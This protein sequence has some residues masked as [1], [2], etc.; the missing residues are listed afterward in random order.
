MKGITNL[1]LQVSPGNQVTLL[2]FGTVHS[3]GSSIGS[4]CGPL[5]SMDAFQKVAAV[6]FAIEKVNSNANFTGISGLH[7]D[8]CNSESRAIYQSYRFLAGDVN[9][10][11]TFIVAEPKTLAMSLFTD[12]EPN[13]GLQ[14]MLRTQGIPFTRT[15]D[16]E[17]VLRARLNA[18]ISI[19]Q[20]LGWSRITVVRKEGSKWGKSALAMLSTEILPTVR[21]MCLGEDLELNLGQKDLKREFQLDLNTAFVLL[22]ETPEET[23]QILNILHDSKK[24]NHIVIASGWDES[25]NY[26][27]SADIFAVAQDSSTETVPGFREFITTTATSN[28]GYVPANWAAEYLDAASN[29]AKWKQAQGVSEIIKIVELLAREVQRLCYQN[30]DVALCGQDPKGFRNEIQATIT[31]EMS[32]LAP[33]LAIWRLNGS[34]NYEQVGHWRKKMGLTASIKKWRKAN[35]TNDCETFRIGRSGKLT[36]VIDEVPNP[37]AIIGELR[38]M[39]GLVTGSLSILGALITVAL[40]VYFAS[41]TEKAV[42]TSILGYQILFGVL[43]LYLSNFTF[44]VAPNDITCLLR[45]LLPSIAY[46]IIVSGMLIKV[47]LITKFHYF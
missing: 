10:N 22:M 31:A 28:P 16:M 19:G 18:A 46:A 6:A 24:K 4:K 40:L 27:G 44:L 3:E 41:A 11:S 47:R 36:S 23:Q 45:R 43:L 26:N 33:N 38:V 42:G 30:E 39:W 14:N 25:I 9:D 29:G 35:A 12:N 34:Q 7:F 13:E 37:P 17:A 8:D 32:A 5:H 21:A 1:F 15:E 20:E 2:S